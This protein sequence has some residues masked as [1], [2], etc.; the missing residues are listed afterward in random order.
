VLDDSRLRTRRLAILNEL[1][2]T[3][4][5]GQITPHDPDGARKIE[6]VVGAKAAWFQLTEGPRL[7]PTQHSGTVAGNFSV[8]WH[9][10]RAT[11]RGL[12]FSRK[13]R[14][15]VMKLSEMPEPERKQL[16]KQSHS[17]CSA[18]SGAGQ[19]GSDRNG[20]AGCKGS[21]RHTREELDFLETAAQTIGIASENLRL[22]EQVLRSQRQGM[23]TFDSIQDLILAHDADFR[24][25]KTNQASAAAAGASASGCVGQSV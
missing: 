24:I 20:V 1:T 4:A 9:N 8:R 12:A 16:A 21:L 15:V 10:S 2:V 25:L 18:G 6:A 22:L 13:I 23:N 17:T 19:E 3:I 5:R 14:A 11:K 7:V